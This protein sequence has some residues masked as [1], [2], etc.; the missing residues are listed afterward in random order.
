[1]VLLNKGTHCPGG[2]KERRWAVGSGPGIAL[3]SS[4]CGPGSPG[5][6]SYRGALGLHTLGWDSEG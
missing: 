3:Q 2:D 1:M 6:G 5:K 4:L